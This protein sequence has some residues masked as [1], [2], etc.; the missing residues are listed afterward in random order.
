M[1]MEEAALFNLRKLMSGKFKPEHEAKALAEIE[2]Q[3]SKVP[4]LNG[5]AKTPKAVFTHLEE[6]KKSHVNR[7]VKLPEKEVQNGRIKR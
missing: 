2:N 5:K 4:L 6:W 7:L 1:R 3:L